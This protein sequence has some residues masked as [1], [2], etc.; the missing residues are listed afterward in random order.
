MGFYRGPNIVTDGL[1]YAMDA[2]SAR[3]YDGTTSLNDLVGSNTGT[4]TNG[5]TYQSINGGVF[6]FDGV[7]DYISFSNVVAND[8]SYTILMWIKPDG[9]SA[10]GS[11]SSKPSGTNRKTPIKGNGQW[12][13]G[14]WLTSDYIRS[15]G[16][17]QYT[18]SAINWTTSTW[19][20]I[21]MTYDGTNV[22]NILG[23]SVQARTHVSSYGPGTPTELLAGAESA[24][25]SSHSWDGS[26]ADVLIY[27]RVLTAAEIAQ[28]YNAKKS[29]FGL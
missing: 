11:G 9:L 19:D 1:V 12:N 26:I 6:D 4:L 8:N 27:D 13:P 21:G 25:G 23:D 16:A 7:D 28:S 22:N 18:D 24:S 14:I 20:M 3:S 17:T 2:G 10:G 5:V 15:H 29:R